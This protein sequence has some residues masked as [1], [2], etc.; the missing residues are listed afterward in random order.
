[1]SSAI[2]LFPYQSASV[3]FALNNKRCLLRLDT[4]L[5]KTLVSIE[6]VKSLENCVNILVIVPA[7]LKHNWNE[8]I[9]KWEGRVNHFNQKVNWD[10]VSYTALAKVDKAIS[11]GKKKYDIVICDE[12]HYMKNWASKRTVNIIKLILVKVR[13]TLLL[14]AT[15]YVRSASDLHPLFSICEP[16]NWS[17]IGSFKNR[18]CLKKPNRF[19]RWEKWDYY[20][21]NPEHAKELTQGAKRFMISYKKKDVLK[22]LPPKIIKNLYIKLPY[23][24]CLDSMDLEEYI[25][26]DTGKIKGGLRE[27]L[28]REAVQLGLAKVP[29]AM[30][31]FES[32]DKNQTVVL[33]CRHREVASLLYVVLRKDYDIDAPMITGETSMTN[34]HRI[35]SDF[36]AGATR[37]LIAT[38]GSCGVGLNLTKA[39]IAGFVEL[40]WS[41][42][43][44]KQCEDRLHRIGQDNCVNIYR[45][46]AKKTIDEILINVIERKITGENLTIGVY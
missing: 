7:F 30:E 35:V 23:Q 18:Y 34:R 26:V 36:Q 20:G 3:A 42:T 24:Y 4:G 13:R 27:I 44:L 38:I 39:S 28:S 5:G 37:V 41:Y 33:F 32:V 40:P 46:L 45:I 1:M 11:Y 31:W 6:T 8:E 16:G 15:P 10:L 43:E 2:N 29:S 25:D 17:T 19:K 21:S 22:D 14:S 12:A 9:D